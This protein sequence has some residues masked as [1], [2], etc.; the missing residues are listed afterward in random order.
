MIGRLR[1]LVAHKAVDRVV[2]DVGGVGYEVAVTPRALVELPPI[3]DEA[4]LHVHTHVREDQ[5]VLFGF[6]MEDQRNLFRMLLGISKLGPTKALAA[7]GTFTPDQLRHVIVT[8]DAEALAA[9]PGIGVRTAQKFI[10][11]LRPKLEL[12]DTP[13]GGSGAASEVREALEGLGYDSAE[14]RAVLK[15]LP[16][17]APVEELLRASLQALGQET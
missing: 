15:E 4:V 1:G 12:P 14:I 3:G 2:L 16:L 9:V 17:D 13:L 6:P 8:E 7:L 5:L 11:E 10:L